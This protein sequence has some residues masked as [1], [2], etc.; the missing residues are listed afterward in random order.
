MLQTYGMSD[1]RKHIDGSWSVYYEPED[2]TDGRQLQL[3]GSLQ[4]RP[5]ARISISAG[6]SYSV[7]VVPS[8]FLTQRVVAGTPSYILAR[9]EQ[10]TA[11]IEARV[12]YAF[13]PTLSFQF[14]AQPF[15][16]AGSYSALAKVVDPRAATPSLQYHA[17]G[18]TDMTVDQ[19]AG[20]QRVFH[21]DTNNDGVADIDV[22]E[23][24][25]NFKQ[26][27]SNAVLRWEYRP[28]SALFVVWSQDRTAETQYGRF[29]LG[30]DLHDLFNE[31]GRNV[32]LIKLSYWLG[33]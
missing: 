24:D 16:S 11:A 29:A 13:S 33:F 1:P 12:N 18:S 10:R 6:P 28:G 7:G 25:F 26:V 9:L 23:P 20:G 21:L 14:Y 2:Q 27:R 5:S 30:R 4:V 19:S 22:S 32:L 15:V 3:T 17:F 8:Q 31:R